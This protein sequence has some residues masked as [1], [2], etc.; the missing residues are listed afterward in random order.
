MKQ[1]VWTQNGTTRE[2]TN[3]KTPNQ[4]NYSEL[5]TDIGKKHKT[6]ANSEQATRGDTNAAAP[7]T[8]VHAKR[9]PQRTPPRT[10]YIREPQRGPDA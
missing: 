8:G 1:T 7:A 6:T 9:G 4:N 10:A 5:R 3:G 2:K